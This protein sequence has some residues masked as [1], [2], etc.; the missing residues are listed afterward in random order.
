M[1]RNKKPMQDLLNLLDYTEGYLQTIRL[2][3][4]EELK[5]K[6]IE[7]YIKNYHEHRRRN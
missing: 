5:P 1:Q 2:K 3:L 4:Q 7:Y 6:P